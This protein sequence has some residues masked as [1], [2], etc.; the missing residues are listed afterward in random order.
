MGATLVVAL[1]GQGQALPYSAWQKSLRR[2]KRVER[3]DD[4]PSAQ[5]AHAGHLRSYTLLSPPFTYF[6]S[7][8]WSARLAISWSKATMPW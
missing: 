7:Q 1:I 8:I 5:M 6:A 4:Q 2:G 3:E